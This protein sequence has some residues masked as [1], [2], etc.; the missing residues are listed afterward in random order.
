MPSVVQSP[1]LASTG[2]GTTP[3]SG[4]NRAAGMCLGSRAFALMVLEVSSLPRRGCCDLLS[5]TLRREPGSA[6]QTQPALTEVA[7]GKSELQLRTA[8]LPPSHRILLSL[9]ENKLLQQPCPVPLSAS[10]GRLPGTRNAAR[11]RRATR[12]RPT[13]PTSSTASLSCSARP[14][15]AAPRRSLYL[16]HAISHGLQYA[17]REGRGAGVLVPDATVHPVPRRSCSGR[18]LGGFSS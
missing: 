4:S 2:R 16:A 10:A 1:A 18:S 14:C 7:R 11:H 13:S 8:S 5:S 12:S 17:P 9:Q 6:V 15:R 3:P